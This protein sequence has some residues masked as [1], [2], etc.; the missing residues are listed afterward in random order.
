MPIFIYLQMAIF[1]RLL[2]DPVWWLKADG[3]NVAS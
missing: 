3:V 1:V 2:F